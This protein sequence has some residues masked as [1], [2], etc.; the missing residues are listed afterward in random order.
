[1]NLLA[2]S[3]LTSPMYVEKYFHKAVVLSHFIID[4]AFQELMWQLV[5]H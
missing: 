3:Q 5:L 4:T 2:V 1:M